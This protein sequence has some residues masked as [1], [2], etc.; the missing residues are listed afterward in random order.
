[1]TAFQISLK[2][3][4]WVLGYNEAG[5]GTG[6]YRCTNFTNTSNGPSFRIVDEDGIYSTI[7]LIEIGF[8]D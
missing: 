7:N 3:D 5:F 4:V 8:T 2:T 1:M 6:H